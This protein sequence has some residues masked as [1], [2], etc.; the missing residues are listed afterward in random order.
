MGCLNHKNYSG[1]SVLTQGGQPWQIVQFL[2][3]LFG[4][5]D[6][7]SK[8]NQMVVKIITPENQER[9]FCR[10]FEKILN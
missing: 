7:T 9:N 4:Q 3:F 5:K 8:N 2:V 10:V 6:E 1:F